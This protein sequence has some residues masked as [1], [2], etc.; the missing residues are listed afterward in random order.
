M[1]RCVGYLAMLAMCATLAGC[2]RPPDRD[3]AG[4]SET[5]APVLTYRIA[6]GMKLSV[7]LSILADADAEDMCLN[8]DMVLSAHGWSDS[9]EV[10]RSGC[11]RL[12]DD[13]AVWLMSTGPRDGRDERFVLT[14]IA[15]GGA[16]DFSKARSQRDKFVKHRVEKLTMS[17]DGVISF[18]PHVESF[19]NRRD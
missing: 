10:P 17:N 19:R 14:S 18:V 7:A 16:D 1:A 15:L 5:Q 13:T 4:Q 3:T 8:Y 2:R 9:R 12:P 11:Y 6:V